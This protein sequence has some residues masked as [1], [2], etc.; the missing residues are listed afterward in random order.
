MGG[1]RER[2]R[3]GERAVCTP[4]THTHT[5]REASLCVSGYVSISLYFCL[6]LSPR[7]SS[8]LSPVCCP[9]L[10]ECINLRVHVSAY[11]RGEALCAHTHVSVCGSANHVCTAAW[12]PACVRT[13]FG[14][15]VGALVESLCQSLSGSVPCPRLWYLEDGSGKVFDSPF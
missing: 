3:A 10:Y 2:E 15:N 1:G 11:N 7:A 6:C 9:S 13:F 4:H 8:Q 14:G 5:H 12:L